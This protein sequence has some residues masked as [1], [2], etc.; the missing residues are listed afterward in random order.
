MNPDQCTHCLNRHTTPITNVI[1]ATD[2][3]Q[4]AKKGER[5]ELRRPPLA[6]KRSTTEPPT[7]ATV[8]KGHAEPC[9][10]RQRPTTP[11]TEEINKEKKIKYQKKVHIRYKP[12]Q[13]NHN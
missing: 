11:E 2:T 6:T 5:E 9:S 8:N 3:T 1:P 10:D 7:C 4:S 13:R 12:T